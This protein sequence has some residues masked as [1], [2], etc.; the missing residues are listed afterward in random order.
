M[1]TKLTIK[2]P[3]DLRRR[4]KAVAA[5]RGESVSDV[6]RAALAEYIEEALE[7]AEDVRAVKE[8]EAKIAAGEP[9]YDHEDVWREIAA[10]QNDAEEAA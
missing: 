2:L 8:V 1:E 3:E 4:A 5:L 7:E 10:H 6:V 9:T